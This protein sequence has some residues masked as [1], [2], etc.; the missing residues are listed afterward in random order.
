MSQHK[1]ILSY[2]SE[3]LEKIIETFNTLDSEDII[4]SYHLLLEHIAPLI[5]SSDHKIAD[6]LNE[7]GISR[8]TYYRKIHTPTLWAPD[9]LKKLI[10]LI[11][12]I[13]NKT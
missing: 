4:D 2:T 11:N 13:Y 10:A 6:I 7:T 8:T 12:K 3:Q 9:E 1:F 5:Q